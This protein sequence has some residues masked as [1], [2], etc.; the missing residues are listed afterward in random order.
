MGVDTT[1]IAAIISAFALVI[2]NQ[3]ILHTQNRRDAA[4][5]AEDEV[6][7][8][9]RLAFLLENFPPHRHEDHEGITYPAGLHPGTSTPHRRT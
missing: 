6:T 3:W 7:K 1:I 2:V 5:K 4:K 9:N 8:D